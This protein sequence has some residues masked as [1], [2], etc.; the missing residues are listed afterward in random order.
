MKVW[1]KIIKK[2]M[3]ITNYDLTKCLYWYIRLRL[4][5]CSSFHVYPHSIIDIDK[6]AIVDIENGELA[7]NVGVNVGWFKSRNR[8]YISEL[9]VL[10]G[11]SIVQRGDFQLNNGASIYV[12]EGAKLVLYGYSLLNTNS[13]INC[14]QYI[15]IGKGCA[16][17]DH[18]SI[19]DSDSH[20]LNSEEDKVSA[21]VIIGNNVWIGKNVTILKG[22]TIGDGAVVGAGSVVVRSI[23]AGC[24]VIGNPARVIKENVTW[25][26]K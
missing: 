2:L 13:T 10:K 18:V 23:P 17:S 3:R 11:G 7:I 26:W 1:N 24:L 19:C 4:P 8:R 20:I 9:R 12:G 5:R 25:K 6:D 22:V 14:F 16:I 15:E 21:P